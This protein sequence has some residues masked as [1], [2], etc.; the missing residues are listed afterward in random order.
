VS[1][2]QCLPNGVCDTVRGQNVTNRLTRTALVLPPIHPHQIMAPAVGISRGPNS[3]PYERDSIIQA[4]ED[5]HTLEN[6]AGQVQRDVPSTWLL[7]P[8]FSVFRRLIDQVFTR[9]SGSG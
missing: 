9:S 5:G 4:Y 1:E 2:Q 6:V 7:Y 8:I 3:T